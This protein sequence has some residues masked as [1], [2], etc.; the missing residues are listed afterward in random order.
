MFVPFVANSR[1]GVQFLYQYTNST[2]SKF[3]RNS[4]QRS[5]YPSSGGGQEV[6]G[7]KS[8][9][10]CG[11]RSASQ[12]TPA[13]STS[14]LSAS[15]PASSA[16]AGAAGS[17]TNGHH[18]HPQRSIDSLDSGTSSQE[19]DSTGGGSGDEVW[20]ECDDET[21]HVITRR[22]F[23]EDLNTNRGFTTPYLLFYQRV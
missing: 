10:C 16:A 5:S 3:C 13:S 21:I 11:V 4:E 22:Q 12:F 14:S 15:E 7:C 9:G 6:G 17:S 8:A 19:Y 1:A 18:S 20:L 23:Q 2:N